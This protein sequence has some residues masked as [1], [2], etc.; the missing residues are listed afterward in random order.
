ME[1]TPPERPITL[2]S[3]K[4]VWPFVL[5]LIGMGVNLFIGGMIWATTNAKLDNVILA[6]K[7]TNEVAKTLTVIVNDHESRLALSEF[8]MDA[9]YAACVIPSRQSSSANTP[10]DTAVASNSSARAI[11]PTPKPATVNVKS[12]SRSTSQ[13]PTSSQPPAEPEEPEE[14]GGVIEKIIE[15]VPEVKLPELKINL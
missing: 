2:G 5:L 7:E 3:I 9:C 8:K 11:T 14:E 1:T 4:G 10:R 12:E 13:Q 15:K 6:Q